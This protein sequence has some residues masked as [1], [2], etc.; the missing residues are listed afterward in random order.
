MTSPLRILLISSHRCLWLAAL[1]GVV[2]WA[3]GCS[4][5]VVGGDILLITVDTLRADHVSTY[6]Y[7]RKTTP[8]TVPQVQAR[9][10]VRVQEVRRRRRVPERRRKG[11]RDKTQ[12][13]IQPGGL[14]QEDLQLDTAIRAAGHLAPAAFLFTNA[15]DRDIQ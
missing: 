6:G 3:I 10:P 9:H 2:V 1:V 14:A 4:E 8:I 11:A 12:T 13:A 15:P 7:G 5:P